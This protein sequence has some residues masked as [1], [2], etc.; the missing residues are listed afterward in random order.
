MNRPGGMTRTRLGDLVELV[1]APAA[2]TVPGDALVGAAAAGWPFGRRTPL[3]AGTSVCLYWAGMA[4]NDWADRDRDADERP[5]RPIPSGR[6]SPGTALG[7]ACGLTAAGLGIAALAG[8]RRALAVAGPLAATAWAYDLAAKTTPAGPVTMAAA[9]TLDVLLGAGGSR[10]AMVAALPAAL[11]VGTHTLGVTELSRGEVAGGSPGAARGALVATGGA[12][13]LSAAAAS[14][15]RGPHRRLDRGA[16]LALTVAYL[17]AV[18]PPQLDA[19]RKPAPELVR[20][21]V[22][23]GILGL[24]PLQASLIARAGAPRMAVLVAAAFPVA[25]RLSRK[26]SPT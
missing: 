21:A 26:V 1:R 12:A 13:A 5:E 9:R 10:A 17:A 3:L 23:A 18:V 8:G 22:G 6:V 4:L 7:L 11:A 16:G 2:L 20:R 14:A 24:V 15:H 25:R 19:A